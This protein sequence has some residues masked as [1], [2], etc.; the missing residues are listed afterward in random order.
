MGQTSCVLTSPGLLLVEIV[1][2]VVFIGPNVLFC[3][4]TPLSCAHVVFCLAAFI[5]LVRGLMCVLLYASSFSGSSSSCFE[6][7]TFSMSPSVP[8]EFAGSVSSA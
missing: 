8:F 6:L 2:R 7:R 5:Y 1:P 4:F 3:S